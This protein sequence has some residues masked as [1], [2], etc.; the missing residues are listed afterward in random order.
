M[1]RFMI[2]IFLVQAVTVVLIFLSPDLEG[3]AWL[4]L[5]FPVVMVGVFASFWFQSMAKDKSKDQLA[6]LKDEYVK[7]KTQR[8]DSYLAEKA[9]L[10]DKHLK[11]KAK[12]QINAERAKTKLVKQ[13][14]KQIARE[15]KVTHG[16]ANFKVGATFAAAIGA[17]ALMLLIELFTFGLMTL[18]TAGGAMGGYYLRAKKES[19]GEALLRKEQ[20]KVI[21][22]DKVGES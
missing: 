1:F 6:N 21:S 7:E 19:K 18:T 4:R 22:A 13:T 11:E 5:A 9:T 10:N 8:E 2:G 16:K 20:L 3:Y 12:I 15:A 14:Q 17:G